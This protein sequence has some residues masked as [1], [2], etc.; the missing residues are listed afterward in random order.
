[1]K[2]FGFVVPDSGDAEVFV[3]SSVLFRSGMTDLEPG[4]HVFIRVE[5]GPRGL[6]A[7]R[8]EPL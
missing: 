8:I 6:Q 1:M 2:G 4:Q 3:H 5:S 7:M